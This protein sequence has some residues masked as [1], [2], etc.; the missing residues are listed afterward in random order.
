MALHFVALLFSICSLVLL[1]I[2]N[3][4]TTFN[5]TFL[6]Q[7][8]LVQ[9][10]EAVTGRYIRYGVYSSCLFYSDSS[11]AHS[12]T[13]KMPGYKFDANQFAELCG[14]DSSNS[15]SA[16]TYTDILNK[17]NITTFQGI[18]LIMP[19]VIL[20]FMAFCCNFSYKF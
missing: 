18:V 17:A 9:V 6:P 3:L 7:M 5:S 19:A 8:Y 12:C 4:G 14:A 1:L 20:V 15:S 2:A 13:N 11:T 16:S 10:N